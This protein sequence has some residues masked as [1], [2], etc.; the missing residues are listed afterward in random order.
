MEHRLLPAL[1]STVACEILEKLVE[2][3]QEVVQGV[4]GR[5]KRWYVRII[6][7]ALDPTK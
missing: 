2:Q 5:Y 6:M 7:N 1:T 3:L 4:G